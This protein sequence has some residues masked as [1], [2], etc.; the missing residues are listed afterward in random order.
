[1]KTKIVTPNIDH[2]AFRDDFIVLLD[3]HAGSV[4]SSEM[5]ALM[6]YTI[7]QFIAMMDSR[8]WTNDL[9]MEILLKNIEE[10][11]KEAIGSASSWMG[12]A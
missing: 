7:G 4:G 1:M 6:S 11:N 2:K 3:K 5:L 8:K 12:S 9:V 10:G